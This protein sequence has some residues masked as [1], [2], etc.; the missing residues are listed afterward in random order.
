MKEKRS[1][2]TLSKEIG[3]KALD[4]AAWTIFR[5]ETVFSYCIRRMELG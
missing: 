4:V 5:G 3:P 1:S 2:A